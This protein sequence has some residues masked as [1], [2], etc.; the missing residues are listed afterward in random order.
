MN[1]I[2][3]IK[4]YI[5]KTNFD[6]TKYYAKT[7]DLFALGRMAKNEP[8]EAIWLAIKFGQAKG[9]RAG[10]AEGNHAGAPG[11]LAALLAAHEPEFADMVLEYAR[12]LEKVGK[13][14]C[15]DFHSVAMETAVLTRERIRNVW[16]FVTALNR[17]RPGV[18]S[19]SRAPAGT[20]EGV[21]V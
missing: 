19:R 14:A 3:R 1:G 16:H 6:S 20:V 12:T 5:D 15:Y 17:S 18:R 9:Y 4:K 13:P 10:K 11:E 2:E 21:G 8:M 7:D